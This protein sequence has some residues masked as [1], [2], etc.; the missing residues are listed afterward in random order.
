[1]QWLNDCI[2]FL[3]LFQ[4]LVE[5]F[6]FPFSKV[7]LQLEHASEMPAEQVRHCEAVLIYFN[8]LFTHVIIYF[9]C[10]Q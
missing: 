5:D 9:G 7:Y 1:M 10:Y 3:L 2:I 6:I 8:C 4:E